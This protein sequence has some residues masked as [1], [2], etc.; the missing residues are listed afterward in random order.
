MDEGKKRRYGARST[1]VQG[2]V[3]EKL[4]LPCEAT[5][6]CLEMIKK[7]YLKILASVGKSVSI[8]FPFSLQIV[9]DRLSASGLFSPNF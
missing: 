8:D 5:G 3:L 6:E 2:S 9:K 4:A 7:K 1:P